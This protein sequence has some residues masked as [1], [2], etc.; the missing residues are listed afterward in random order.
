MPFYKNSSVFCIIKLLLIRVKSKTHGCDFDRE[1]WWLFAV[2][3]AKAA[4][5]MKVQ[6]FRYFASMWIYICIYIYIYIFFLSLWKCL[7]TETGVQWNATAKEKEKKKTKSWS[8]NNDS[9][10]VC[11]VA[12][13]P[14]E[15]NLLNKARQKF[16]N[17]KLQWWRDIPNWINHRFQ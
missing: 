4:L 2:N 6:I 16:T 8:G 3:D 15:A 9:S 5:L 11:I 14:R 7:P 1:Q 13:D 17:W 10:N 12:K